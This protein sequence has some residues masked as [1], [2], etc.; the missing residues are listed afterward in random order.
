M[1]SVDADITVSEDIYRNDIEKKIK[2]I[3]EI[4][5]NR[6]NR[7]CYQS[8]HNFLIRDSQY[9][10]IEKEELKKIINEM[11]ENGTLQNTGSE[12]KESYR[13]P[14]SKS[15]GV[16]EVEEGLCINEG[17][18]FNFDFY[19][20]LGQFLEKFMDKV[21]Q[22][23]NTKIA[24]NDAKFD[25]KFDEK[26]DAKFD[27][28]GGI[29]PS[30]PLPFRY[31]TP[32]NHSFRQLPK[33][34]VVNTSIQEKSDEGM[35][36]LSSLRDEIKFLRNELKSR[37]ELI[38]TLKTEKDIHKLTSAYKTTLLEN[39]KSST[40]KSDS[41]RNGNVVEIDVGKKPHRHITETKGNLYIRTDWSDYDERN[42]LSETMR[43]DDDGNGFSES[44]N[45][46]TK[47]PA[48]KTNRVITII[49]DS[50]I[51]DVQSHK[52][53]KRLKPNERLYVKSFP[54]AT[55]EDMVDYVRPTMRRSPD[56]IVLHAGTNN[57]RSEKSAKDIANDTMKLVL[58]MKTDTNDVMVSSLIARSDDTKLYRKSLEVN[59]FLKDDCNRY[60]LFFIDNTNI[61]A[62]KHLNGSGLHLNYR[63]TVTLVRHFTESIK[64]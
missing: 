20:K 3:V 10:H 35:I 46:R 31:Q 17:N 64:I 22:T 62:G 13:A 23:I 2:N 49:G 32:L 37:D 15:N 41:N 40:V 14:T 57:L 12:E 28:N 55:I 45:K 42:S 50:T 60:D 24:V 19:P 59:R 30:T 27:G 36:Q 43:N 1:I 47:D 4:I 34:P 25:A 54:G 53:R 33:I 29:P 16:T 21:V 61:E 11:V 9:K 63:G 5:T 52:M 6:R 44:T 26:F 58:E 8:I 7:P 18:A 38:G 56:L 48:K 51:K 39:K